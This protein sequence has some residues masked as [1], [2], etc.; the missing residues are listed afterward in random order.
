MHREIPGFRKR[1]VAL[2]K[3]IAIL[4]VMIDGLEPFDRLIGQIGRPER[5]FGERPTVGAVVVT[6]L[7][8]S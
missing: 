1:N 7:S 6:V 3:T 8:K 5:V 2:T 4:G